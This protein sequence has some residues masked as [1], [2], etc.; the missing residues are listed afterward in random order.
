MESHERYRT[1]LLFGA[2]GA[3]KGT[4]GAV[5]GSIPGFFHLSCGDV[6]RSIDIHSPL[7][8]VICEYTSRGDL[9]PDEVTVELWRQNMHAR[10]SLSQYRPH[11]DIL[12]LDGIPRSVTQA[13]LLE[14]DIDVLKVVHL[15][16]KDQRLMV[17]RLRKRALKEN[18]ADDAR[19]D[20]ILRRWQVY[21]K[22]TQPVL[23]YYREGIAV[24]GRIAEVDAAQSPAEVLRDVLTHVIPVQNAELR[25]A[26]KP[27]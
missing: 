10:T 17:E 23:D 19:E 24:K 11:S 14:R 15:E 9:V 4:Q 12:V 5:L 3:G 21:Q 25:K 13:K 6:F 26:A 27:R 16:C 20:V 18:R 7:G 8:K 1:V 2:P 22:E